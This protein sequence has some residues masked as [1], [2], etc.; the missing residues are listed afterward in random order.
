MRLSSLSTTRTTRGEATRRFG[1]VGDPS[2]RILWS[3]STR[4]LACCLA[5]RRRGPGSEKRR[6]RWA[7][8]ARLS[9]RAARACARSP[10]AAPAPPSSNHS[11]I[12]KTASAATAGAS[13]APSACSTARRRVGSA[14]RT[15]R[16]HFSA[17][18]RVP[19][20]PT[21]K[22]GPKPTTAY[23]CLGTRQAGGNANP[24]PR[25]GSW[26][27]S[28]AL[29]NEIC[30]R[31]SPRHSSTNTIASRVVAPGF[32]HVSACAAPASLRRHGHVSALTS[33]FATAADSN[34]PMARTHRFSPASSKKSSIIA[35]GL[36]LS[37]SSVPA[38]VVSTE[39]D[40]RR[41]ASPGP[42]CGGPGPSKPTSFVEDQMKTG[43][44]LHV[45]SWV[46]L[47]VASQ[48]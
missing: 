4:I 36:R 14:A 9:R 5:V 33:C 7:S 29:L 18:R 37:L 30:S 25:P 34:T 24:F 47:H 10:R 6:T 17:S 11:Y 16:T 40:H 23:S 46:V 28:V 43:V 3:V 15:S 22:P 45:A 32:C 19:N 35:K 31:S 39:N 20:A 26:S 38:A 48:E 12:S 27:G 44:V 2:T 13:V 8:A 41:R 21:S 1:S 42:S